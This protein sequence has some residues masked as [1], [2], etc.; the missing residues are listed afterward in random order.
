MAHDQ[1]AGA[2][3]QAH[4]TD[5]QIGK[6]PNPQPGT[7]KQLHDRPVATGPQTIGLALDRE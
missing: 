7:Q 3:R 6:L 1:L 4:I 2:L 5:V